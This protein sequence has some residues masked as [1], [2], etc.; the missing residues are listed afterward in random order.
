MNVLAPMRLARH[1]LTRMQ[2]EGRGALLTISSMDALQPTPYHSVYGATKAFVNSLL[3]H[4][5]GSRIFAA[6]APQH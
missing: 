2:T 3:P 1:A 5:I 6:L 4:R